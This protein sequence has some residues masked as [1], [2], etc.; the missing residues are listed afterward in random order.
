M[1]SGKVKEFTSLEIMHLLNKEKNGRLGKAFIKYQD[2]I[3]LKDYI[4]TN[5]K[6]PLS[7][8]NLE[9]VGIKLSERFREL[10][11]ANSPVHLNMIVSTL[12]LQAS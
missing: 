6:V 8:T 10:D 2:P 11:V 7:Y 12:I 4:Q 5:I 3:N 1:M 9:E